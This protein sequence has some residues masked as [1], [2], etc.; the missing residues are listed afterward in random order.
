M[1]FLADTPAKWK[2]LRVIC[3]VG[4]PIDCAATVP[5]ISPGDAIAC[6]VITFRLSSPHKRGQDVHQNLLWVS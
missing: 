5:I 3:V 6:E 1:T 4:S 2:V